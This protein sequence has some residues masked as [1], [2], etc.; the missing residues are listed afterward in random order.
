M[1]TVSQ[2]VPTNPQRVTTADGR[3]VKVCIGTPLY[4]GLGYATYFISLINTMN[5]LS[6]NG[7]ECE[8]IFILGESLITRAR[9]NIV[10]KFLNKSEATHLMFIDGDISWNPVEVLKLLKHDKDLV[11]GIYPM[12]TYKWEN[13]NDLEKFRERHKS[14]LHKNVP[15]NEFVRQNLMKYNLN[16]KS[17]SFGVQNNLVEVKHIATGFMMIK[18]ATLEKTIMAHPELKFWDDM[19]CL[20][21]DEDRFAYTLFDCQTV[22][23]HYFSEDWLFC[24][25]WEKIGGQIF[26]DVTINLTH[27]G[28]HQFPGRFIS[29]LNLAQKAPTDGQVPP[30]S[31]NSMSEAQRKLIEQAE[32]LAAAQSSEQRNTFPDK[33]S[34]TEIQIS[35]TTPKTDSV[36]PRVQEITEEVKKV[37]IS[38]P[39]LI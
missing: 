22:E 27:S 28:T 32:K 34:S 16:Y 37:Q 12:K 20:N 24:H 9:N 25:R 1:S 8:P 3:P 26:V 7:I 38:E 6:K 10:A 14:D 23:G 11:G 30:S 17:A 15:F 31:Q 4:G 13:L 5:L 19:G 33:H 29:S 18:R 36:E 39:K 2:P 35:G 21:K